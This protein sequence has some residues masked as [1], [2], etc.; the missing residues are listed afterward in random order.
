MN[1]DDI[2]QLGTS[3]T[4]DNNIGDW[5]RIF[6]ENC[7]MK[8]KSRVLVAVSMCIGFHATVNLTH[9]SGLHEVLFTMTCFDDIF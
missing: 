5:S 2:L 6:C 3:A 8:N 7:R 1:A 9:I 4:D